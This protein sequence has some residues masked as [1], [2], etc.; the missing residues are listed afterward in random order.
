VAKEKDSIM[1][2]SCTKY[3]CKKNYPEGIPNWCA[4]TGFRDVLDSTK[5]G[6][7]APDNL[8]IYRAA[9]NV[10]QKGY[11]KWPRIR[12]AVEF[13]KELGLKKI[14]LASC[15]GLIS[16]L[17]LVTKLFTDAGFEVVSI[18]CQIGKVSPEER[19]VTF[20][21]K[22]NHGLTCNPIAQ[23]G[24]CNQEGTQLNFL[25]GLCLGHDILFMRHSNAP[26]STLI[27]K[28][29]V[30]GHNPAAVLY[31]DHLRRSLFKAC[32]EK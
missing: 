27:V 7:A 14:G 26:V 12:E 30:T 11:E 22:G 1:C 20:N 16:E 25:L 18:A 6:Y 2:G 24:I 28:D 32:S 17:G 19:G 10:I 13:S 29:R 15:V 21:T 3:E 5:K 8:E 4:A 31:A 9:A 23:A